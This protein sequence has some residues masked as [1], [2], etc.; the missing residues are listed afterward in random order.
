MQGNVTYAMDFDRLFNNIPVHRII[1]N[2]DIVCRMPLVSHGVLG[3]RDVSALVP[4]ISD[5]SLKVLAQSAFGP[6]LGGLRYGLAYA[7]TKGIRYLNSQRLIGTTSVEPNVN[8]DDAISTNF[9]NYDENIPSSLQ[10]Y[11]L[12]DHNPDY[13]VRHCD[14]AARTNIEDGWI[15]RILSG[16]N[17]AKILD[18][19]LTPTSLLIEMVDPKGKIF[20]WFVTLVMFLL[21][22]CVPFVIAAGVMVSLYSTIVGLIF[23]GAKEDEDEN[24]NEAD[25]NRR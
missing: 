9:I 1:N 19:F 6:V 25:G 2:D 11:S 15:K 5:A 16:W 18:L 20:Y 21:L 12:L 13:Y 10:F 24:E 3:E 14:E 8:V 4:I 22:L 17:L 23:G 7:G